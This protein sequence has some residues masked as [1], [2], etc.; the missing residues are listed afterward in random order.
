MT[1]A[2][3]RNFRAS[4]RYNALANRRLYEACARLPD[5]ERK[6]RRLAFF[7]SIHGTL[8]YITLGDRIW[9]ARFSGEEIPSTNLDA[10]LHEVG[11]WR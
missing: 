10:V 9:L 6:K 5:D 8:N 11:R 2:L 3:I 1:D 7:G 4:A